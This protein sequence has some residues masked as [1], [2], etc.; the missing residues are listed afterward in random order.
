VPQRVRKLPRRRSCRVAAQ[1]IAAT[2]LPRADMPCHITTPAQVHTA[3]ALCR[4]SSA[5]HTTATSQPQA[6]PF[7]EHPPHTQPGP[8]AS[9]A[10]HT[11][12]E[13][14]GIVLEA[15]GQP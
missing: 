5:L 13:E 7:H 3:A 14:W 10:Q 2:T 1:G 6:G 9:S 12:I 4:T 11:L 15:N 8:M